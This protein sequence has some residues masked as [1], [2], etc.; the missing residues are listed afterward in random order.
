MRKRTCVA[1]LVTLLVTLGVLDAPGN[2]WNDSERGRKRVAPEEFAILPW[3]FI[4]PDSRTLAE[5]HDCGFNLAGFV[6]PKYVDLVAKAGLKCVVFDPRIQATDK[7]VDMPAE[8][9]QSRVDAVVRD[10]G[11]SPAVFGFY[12]RDEPGHT[13]FPSLARWADALRKAAPD[14]PAY[15]NLYPCVVPDYV[16]TN[17]NY[18]DYVTS[19]VEMVRPRFISYDHYTILEDGSVRETFYQN[20]ETVRRVSL[21]HGIPFW[22][23]VLS[24]AHFTYADPSPASLRLQAF[25]TLAYGARGISYFTYLTPAIGNFRLAPIDPF[26]NKTPTWDMLR[27]VNLQIHTLAPEYL[28]LTSVNVFHHPTVPPGCNG[29]E[30]SRFLKGLTEADL[31]VGEFTD[32]EGRPSMLV[33]NKSLTASKEFDVVFKEPGRIMMVNSYTGHVGPW[34]GEHKWL[35]PGQGMLLRPEAKPE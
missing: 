2:G 4:T 5:L 21:K 15:I 10:T 11:P 17:G 23:I 16:L 9:I 34:E 32:A 6:E 7:T 22:N 12:L 31:V 29:L 20:L 13:M 35:A 18:E 24:N 30:S 28:K 26:G 1:V 33:V 25:T 27:E 19:Y 14:K 8:E 3:S